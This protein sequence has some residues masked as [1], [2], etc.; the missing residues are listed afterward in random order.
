MNS[1]RIK[2]TENALS[3][4]AAESSSKDGPNLQA[5]E[6]LV[7][8]RRQAVEARTGLSRSSIYDRIAAGEFPKPVPLGGRTVGWVE[9]E[10]REWQKARIAERA[11]KAI[12]GIRRPGP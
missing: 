10:I 1:G 4:R 9:A 5:A 12:L 7:F 2:S 11:Q 3:S 8:L 6:K